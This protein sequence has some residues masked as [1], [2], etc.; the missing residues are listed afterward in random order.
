MAETTHFTD[1]MAA[2]IARPD[3]PSPMANTG[4]MF[5][6]MK[7]EGATPERD[8]RSREAEWCVAVHVKRL[9]SEI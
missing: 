9:V 7:V 1:F 4:K 8:V 2:T 6:D 5:A 3:H